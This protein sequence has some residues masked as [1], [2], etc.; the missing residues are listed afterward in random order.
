MQNVGDECT[1]LLNHCVG[2]C[3]IDK[4]KHDILQPLIYNEP[5]WHLNNQF[6]ITYGEITDCESSPA[7]NSHRTL[8]GA[9]IFGLLAFTPSPQSNF[10]FW[11]ESLQIYPLVEM[12]V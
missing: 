9:L 10:N 6:L 8:P 5:S 1:Y 7:S 3:Y 11:A 12:I 2:E 4:T